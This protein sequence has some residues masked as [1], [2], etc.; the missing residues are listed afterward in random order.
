MRSIPRSIFNALAAAMGLSLAACAAA[1]PPAP[2]APP[3]PGDARAATPPPAPLP[4]EEAF[5]VRGTLKDEW[6]PLLK[7][8]PFNPKSALVPPTP[9][10]VPAPPAAC[11]AF[12]RRAPVA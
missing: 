2:N 5:A 4:E 7:Q 6:L 9:A 3:A 8:T 12:A 1:P 11:E 10:G